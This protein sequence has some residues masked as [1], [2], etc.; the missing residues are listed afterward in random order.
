MTYDAIDRTT[1][2]HG[3][4][5]DGL[6]PFDL[7]GDGRAAARPA[8]AATFGRMFNLTPFRPPEPLL[9]NLAEIMREPPASTP[10]WK[11][12]AR[13]PAGYI[14]FGQFLTHDLTYDPSPLPALE[15]ERNLKGLPN[16][17]TPRFDLDPVYAEPPVSTVAAPRIGDKFLIAN[18]GHA[19][20]PLDLMRTA[21]GLALIPDPRNDENVLISQLHVAFM[22][23]HNRFVD[24]L[25]AARR[26]GSPLS[27]QPD[28]QAAKR[29]CQWHYQ[30]LIVNDYLPEVVQRATINS[31]RKFGNG[32]FTITTP[33]YTPSASATNPPWIPV[34]LATAA[35]RF[36]HSML[37]VTYAV[38][39]R[40]QKAKT[41]GHDLNE[42]VLNGMRP[43]P[44]DL[45]VKWDL[46]FKVPG[47]PFRPQ[48]KARALDSYLPPPLFDLPRPLLPPGEVHTQPF[49][50]ALRDLQRGRRYGLPSG[51]QVAKAMADKVPGTPVLENRVIFRGHPL[52]ADPGWEGQAPLWFYILEEAR[53]LGKGETLGPVGGRIVAEVFLKLLDLDKDSYLHAR[54]IF[55]PVFQPP[56]TARQATVGDL[57]AYA[58]VASG[59]TPW[60][61]PYRQSPS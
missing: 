46:F 51:Q 30:W 59:F 27:S 25:V 49:S 57:L 35:L 1:A 58:G 53:E 45:K 14:T 7:D 6:A 18:E 44:P 24:D 47:A 26:A 19:S 55:R 33:C 23:L 4:I 11:P 3:E 12:Y 41:F 60:T 56:G 20:K 5:P 22:K 29:L 13:T 36:G 39:S 2:R 31:I 38:S 50:L 28:F 21:N 15:R 10:L 9:H 32:R 52:G 40:E 16:I 54:P 17:R 34:E 43:I 48:N 42:P 61:G 8:G 37:G